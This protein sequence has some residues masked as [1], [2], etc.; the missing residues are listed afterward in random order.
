M[1][2]LLVRPK[3]L[4]RQYW[5]SSLLIILLL[6]GL[7]S[8]RAEAQQPTEG[9]YLTQVCGDFLARWDKKPSALKFVRCETVKSTQV[10]RLVSTYTVK[11]SDAIDAEKFLQRQF[12]MTPLRFRCCYWSP[13][14]EKG[15]VAPHY[16]RYIDPEGAKFEVFMSS[17]ETL[18]NSR[19]AWH[20]IP[21]FHI[22]VTTYLG[23]F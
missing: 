15:G 22:E 11:G 18:L 13:G 1:A 20:K 2:I 9:P 19:R 21:E 8:D 23:E 6:L 7:V 16:G 17:G 14:P 10:D 3:R 5:Q 12:G 4:S